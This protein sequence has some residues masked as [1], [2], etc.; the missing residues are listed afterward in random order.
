MLQMKL[1]AVIEP[2]CNRGSVLLMCEQKFSP[3]T[4]LNAAK[5]IAS[6]E[7]TFLC[8]T[9]IFVFLTKNSP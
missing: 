5:P 3:Y 2:L 9:E 7:D 4:V 8:Y 6:S 1:P